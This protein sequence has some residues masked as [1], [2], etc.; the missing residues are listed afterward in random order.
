MKVLV[1]GGAGFIGSHLVDALLARRDEVRILDNL[2]T[3]SRKNLPDSAEL[4][5]GDVAD[6]EAVR[7]S[8][9]GCDLIFHEAALV[10]VPISVNDP[11]KNHR[12]NVD[13]TFHVFEAARQA[14]IKRVVYASSAAIYGNLPDLPKRES[15]PIA[16]IT[17]YAT[18]KLIAEQ[19]ASVY[20]AA[21]GLECVGL[22]YMNV[23]G[24][25]QN[26][27]SPYSGVLSIFCAAAMQNKGVTIFGDGEQSRD[28]VYVGDVVQANLLA[29]SA[30]FDPAKSFFNVGC[31]QQTSLN[32]I[33][34]Q[35]RL[36]MNRPIPIHY[37][38]E[39][40]GDIRHSL[41]DIAQARQ[42][43]NFDPQVDLSTGL[44]QTLAWFENETQL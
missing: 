8:A 21:Y 9:E 38:A 36:L 11:L 31:G 44:A 16:P 15:S 12:D 23:Y 24:P 29:S 22:R 34:E 17:P 1:T 3:G 25:R 41:A 28:F 33:V 10:S 43:L 14:G 32:Q 18:A 42:Q 7:A 37:A 19:Y 13:G 39:R 6:W 2:S 4:I 26:P 30:P 20:H 35:L 5:V 27:G 40:V